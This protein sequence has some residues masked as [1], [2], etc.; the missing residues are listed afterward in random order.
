MNWLAVIPVALILYGAGRFMRTRWI[1]EGF[2]RGCR[3]E[4]DIQKG[5]DNDI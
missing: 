5:I 2:R 1:A 4:R 3:F